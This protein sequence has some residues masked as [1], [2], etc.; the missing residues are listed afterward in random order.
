MY[1]LPF[2]IF[3]DGQAVGSTSA[4]QTATFTNTGRRIQW[5]VFVGR[6]C[7]ERGGRFSAELGV[8]RDGGGG[9]QLHDWSDVQADDRGATDGGFNGSHQF[10]GGAVCGA[11]TGNGAIRHLPGFTANI[12]VPNDDGSSAKCRCRSR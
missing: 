8:R 7:R 4:P 5:R 10:A 11:L 12:I 9:K 1:V 3:Y 2:E 6:G